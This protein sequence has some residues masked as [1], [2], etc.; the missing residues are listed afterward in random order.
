MAQACWVTAFTLQS[1]GFTTPGHFRMEFLSRPGTSYTIEFK[2]SLAD[3]TW[4]SFVANGTFTATN[5]LSAF[6]D[7]FTPATSGGPSPTGHR[8]YRFSYVTP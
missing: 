6:E 1:A 7:D 4:Q 2:N 3:A 8:F 5:T